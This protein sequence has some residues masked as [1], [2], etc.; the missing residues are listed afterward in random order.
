M[1]ELEVRVNMGFSP[2]LP[3]G[4]GRFFKFLQFVFDILDLFEI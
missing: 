3:P 1:G 2:P 4:E